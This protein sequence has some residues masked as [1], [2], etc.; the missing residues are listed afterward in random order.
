MAAP[1]S[2]RGNGDDICMDQ[3]Y[4]MVEIKASRIPAVNRPHGVNDGG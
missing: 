3:F 1:G 2:K 4:V